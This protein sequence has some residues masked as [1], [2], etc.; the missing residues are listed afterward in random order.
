MSNN[1]ILR[2]KTDTDSDQDF[3]IENEMIITNPIN[4][5]NLNMDIKQ[6]NISDFSGEKEGQIDYI[7]EKHKEGLKNTP[8]KE[9][10]IHLDEKGITNEKKK[11]VKYD[12]KIMAQNFNDYYEASHKEINDYYE[13]NYPELS[14]YE[15]KIDL[16]SELFKLV[17]KNKIFNF[18]ENN[19]EYNA[20]NNKTICTN[21]IKDKIIIL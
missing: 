9:H 7:Y 11:K 2:N 6:H 13:V 20:I 15:L 19:E 8:N 3:N 1:R 14:N 10:I 5:E 18:I 12:K 16:Y 21:I 17:D 4:N